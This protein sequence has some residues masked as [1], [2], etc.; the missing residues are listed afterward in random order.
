MKRLT[1]I[2]ALV[3]TS[4]WAQEPTQPAASA[5][6]FVVLPLLFVG[7]GLLL[8]ARNSYIS[9]VPQRFGFVSITPHKPRR[10]FPLDAYV[11][12]MEP[13]VNGLADKDIHVY[14]NLSKIT[15]TH[16]P[17]GIF[18]EEKNYKISVL[19]NRRRTRRCFLQN[20][21]ILDMGELTLMFL[22]PQTEVPVAEV[23]ED[24]D[25]PE[26]ESAIP[27]NKRIKPKMLKSSPTLIPAD[28]R[29]K[30]YYLTKNITYV[31]RSE[32]NDLVSKAKG[33]SL[34]HS[35]IE[36]V[37]GRFK[38]LDLDSSNG[39]FVNGRR[40]ENKFLRDGD[41][42]SFESVKYTFSLSGKTR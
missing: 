5:H 31:G 8:W 30:T 28:T 42:I 29:K 15:L 11:V 17:N 21:D 1:L 37:S 39:T 34:R 14:S 13:V 16:K 18:M 6:L 9:P 40:V 3:P 36:K 32:M 38:L 25:A 27:K 33:V 12:D 19:V 4:L 10:F 2:L 22:S 26:K 7:V 35:K 41:I 23:S 20:G 24:D